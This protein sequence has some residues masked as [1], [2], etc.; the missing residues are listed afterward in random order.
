MENVFFLRVTHLDHH[1]LERRLELPLLRERLRGAEPVLPVDHG[2]ESH[3]GGRVIRSSVSWGFVTRGLGDLD[4]RDCAGPAFYRRFALRGGDQLGALTP[5]DALLVPQE[6]SRPER[7]WVGA[8]QPLMPQ[9]SEERAEDGM[10]DRVGASLGDERGVRLCDEDGGLALD[11]PLCCELR[12]RLR[13]GRL[14]R[15]GPLLL[16]LK[17]ELSEDC[18][19]LF[20]LQLQLFARPL[21]CGL[22]VECPV[23]HLGGGERHPLRLQQLRRRRAQLALDGRQ[24]R[25][26]LP[27][28]VHLGLDGAE[29]GGLDGEDLGE[30]ELLR[31]Q[32]THVVLR[33]LELSKVL[34]RARSHRARE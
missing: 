24:P 22:G 13:L 16:C 15:E 18:L 31:R 25:R 12:R 34:G 21:E 9:I 5:E 2:P 10:L 1:L 26:L 27:E 28:R 33:L 20:L 32:T 6:C 11:V 3:R 17:L 30:F 8:V 19:E 29:G 23:L 7:P 4:Y 14:L